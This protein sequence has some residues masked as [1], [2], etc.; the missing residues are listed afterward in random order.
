MKVWVTNRRLLFGNALDRARRVIPLSALQSIDA[1]PIAKWP[2]FQQS[3]L[4]RYVHTGR[5]EAL[6]VGGTGRSRELVR[7]IERALPGGLPCGT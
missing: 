5:S 2:P 6:R 1:T 3:M 4:V 7:A